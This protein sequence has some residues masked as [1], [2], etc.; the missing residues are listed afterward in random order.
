MQV[1]TKIKVSIM[2]AFGRSRGGPFVPFRIDSAG[3]MASRANEA[4]AKI[5][6]GIEWPIWLGV[7]KTVSPT[8]V[9]ADKSMTIRPGVAKAFE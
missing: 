9:K 8:V 3:Q 6:W 7:V 2:A 4:M 5:L 1:A